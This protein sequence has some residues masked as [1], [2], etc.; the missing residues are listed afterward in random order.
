MASGGGARPCPPSGA[1]AAAGRPVVAVAPER[2]VDQMLGE[3]SSMINRLPD[4]LRFLT[5]MALSEA[6][7]SAEPIRARMVAM[8]HHQTT[9]LLRVEISRMLAEAERKGKELLSQAVAV[10]VSKLL[11]SRL[12]SAAPAA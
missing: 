10:A 7:K 4:G 1:I 9:F 2:A 3:I 12:P 5:Q 11:Q 8:I 6:M